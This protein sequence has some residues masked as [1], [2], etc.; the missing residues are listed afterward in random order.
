[1]WSRL[2][3]RPTRLGFAFCRRSD[4]KNVTSCSDSGTRTPLCARNWWVRGVPWNKVAN[5]LLWSHQNCGRTYRRKCFLKLKFVPQPYKMLNPGGMLVKESVSCI[6]V[7]SFFSNFC[8]FVPFQEVIE[9]ICRKVH[10]LSNQ[11]EVK[12]QVSPQ[13][14]KCH[15]VKISFGFYW[16]LLSC[17]VVFCL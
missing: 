1:M 6:L 13:M 2:Y 16:W 4:R 9:K 7:Q 11:K 10:K 15:Q 14:S 17:S 5:I 3:A 8:A 12:A